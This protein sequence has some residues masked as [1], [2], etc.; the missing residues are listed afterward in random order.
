MIRMMATDDSITGPINIGN[1]GEFTMLELA[2]EIINITGTKSKIVYMPLPKDDPT[3]RQPDIT[4]AREILN[5]WEP[6]VQLREGLIQTIN[7]F[8][9]LLSNQKEK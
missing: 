6:K 2:S 7:Y 5:G 1:Q 3:Q 8:D 9:E 4:L